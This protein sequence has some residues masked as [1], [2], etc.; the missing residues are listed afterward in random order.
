MGDKVEQTEVE[1][2]NAATR[3]EGVRFEKVRRDQ[4]VWRE[5]LA[6]FPQRKYEET[7]ES[8]NEHHN[9]ASA[10]PAIIRLGG[11]GEGD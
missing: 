8:D 1:E 11:N 10:C 3:A 4:G 2:P 7:D 5:F 6:R 9:N